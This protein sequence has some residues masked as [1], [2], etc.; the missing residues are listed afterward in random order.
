MPKLFGVEVSDEV[1]I[2]N[3][4]LDELIKEEKSSARKEI[5]RMQRDRLERRF[6]DIWLSLG[7]A[8]PPFWPD[9][10][11]NGHQFDGERGWHID[12]Y[13]RRTCTGVE[14]HGGQ[15]MRKSGH[16]NARGQ[17]RDWEKL[18]RCHELGIVLWGFTTAMVNVDDVGRLMTFCRGRLTDAPTDDIVGVC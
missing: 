10:W 12:R 2:K 6:D 1:Y 18:N 15:F 16:S 8:E 9:F 11:V 7:G 13:N 17:Q 5:D 4:H 14:I 3:R